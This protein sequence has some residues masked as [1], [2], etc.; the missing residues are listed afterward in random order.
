M[1]MLQRVES[2]G[3]THH[4]KWLSIVRILLGLFLLWVGILFVMNRDALDAIINESPALVTLSFFIAHYI[5]FAHVVGGLFIAMGLLT[6]ICALANIPILLG[7][8]FFVH[9]PTGLFHV[10]PVL[11]LSILVLFLLVFFAVVGSGRISVDEFMRRHPERQRN[12]KYI[13]F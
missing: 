4:P 8:V 6:R 11:S 9:S 13:D 1:N 5:V 3:D 7:A 2:W 10:Y 12:R